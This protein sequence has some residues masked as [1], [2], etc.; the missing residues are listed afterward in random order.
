[1]IEPF[2]SGRH[3]AAVTY[4]SKREFDSQREDDDDTL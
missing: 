2:D 4:Q 1:L 3:L